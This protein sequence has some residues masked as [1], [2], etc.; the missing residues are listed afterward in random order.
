M[1]GSSR[2]LVI[3]AHIKKWVQFFFPGCCWW[4][5]GM[6]Q[7]ASS[8]AHSYCLLQGA[9]G[10]Q[11]PAQCKSWSAVHP[12]ERTKPQPCPSRWK[13]LVLKMRPLVSGALTPAYCF[14]VPVNATD[15][16]TPACK[17]KS[18]WWL[19]LWKNLSPS[20]HQSSCI[21]LKPDSVKTHLLLSQGTHYMR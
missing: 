7:S 1:P 10:S 11:I 16:L 8:F 17:L 14:Y 15:P 18:T 9:C 5:R 2:A 12:H 20:E 21:C 6:A 4:N 3:K 13:W 19:T